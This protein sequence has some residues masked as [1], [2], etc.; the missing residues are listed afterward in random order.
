MKN[1]I[2]IKNKVFG[3]KMKKLILISLLMLLILPLFAQEEDDTWTRRVIKELVPPDP[4]SAKVAQVFNWHIRPQQVATTFYDYQ[5]GA[6][7]AWSFRIQPD[8][9]A[10]PKGIFTFMYQAQPNPS[11][12]PAATRRQNRLWVNLTDTG[13]GVIAEEST[14]ITS[15]NTIRE[16]FGTLGIDPVTGTPFYVWHTGEGNPDPVSAPNLNLKIAYELYHAYGFPGAGYESYTFFDNYAANH[17]FETDVHLDSYDVKEDFSWP[18]IYIGDSPLANHRRIYIFAHNNGYSMAQTTTEPDPDNE[19]EFLTRYYI[20]DKP[21]FAYCDFTTEDLATMK[22]PE[23][24]GRDSLMDPPVWV[25]QKNLPYFEDLHTWDNSIL[26]DT[27]FPVARAY[28]NATVQENGPGVAIT[29]TIIADA[30]ADIFAEGYDQHDNVI[31]YNDNYG[32]SSDW[33][34]YPFNLMARTPTESA[35]T[36]FYK[37]HYSRYMMRF[38]ESGNLVYDIED[39]DR[40]L[41]IDE[42]SGEPGW[43]ELEFFYMDLDKDFIYAYDDQLNHKSVIFDEQGNLNMPVIYATAS[44]NEEDMIPDPDST[45]KKY[46]YPYNGWTHYY[47]QNS[48]TNVKFNPQTENISLHRVYPPAQDPEVNIPIGPYDN[49]PVLPFTW[50]TSGDPKY[51]DEQ[52]YIHILPDLDPD[53][54]DYDEDEL[55]LHSSE[56][57]YPYLI[58]Y[59]TNADMQAK[60]GASNF[61]R[62]TYDNEGAIAMMWI[63]TTKASRTEPGDFDRIAEICISVSLD[64]G[65]TWSEP[66]RLNKRDNPALVSGPYQY[67]TFLYPADKIIKLTNDTVRVYF[68][69]VNS[70]Y[71]GGSYIQ[72]EFNLNNSANQAIFYACI[73]ISVSDE[74]VSGKDIVETVKPKPL[75]SHNYPN[76]FNPSTTIMFNVPS[77][78]KVNLSIYNIKGQLVKT[79]I[80]EPLK[81][82]PNTIVWNGLDNN[83]NQTASGVYFY[84][85]STSGRTEVKKMV[86]MK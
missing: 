13:D 8:N 62:T 23:L 50:S 22:N 7:N 59:D 2:K 19:G 47:F 61:V 41:A 3:G 20:S 28:P 70:R 84:K 86:L 21:L 16:G 45:P 44:A 71:W 11:L 65:N 76:P 55:W 25:I 80:D 24:F 48:L 17:D 60:N 14:P 42:D 32:N 40:V 69:Y 77:D 74:E 37:R 54:P 56:N 39:G 30:T 81:A 43:C 68:M 83:N 49:A 52:Y 33:Q 72:G 75:L 82:G 35:D 9:V 67:P 79:L 51:I 36:P 29:A 46:G 27:G 66:A 1:I 78:G 18:M 85:M 5:T 4:G 31:V 38:S 10:D 64:H 63:D 15:I 57:L 58:P 53:S 34:V 6:Y 73:D 12:G 26:G